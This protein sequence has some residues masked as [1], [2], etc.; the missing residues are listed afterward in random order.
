M[1]AS[2]TEVQQWG[3]GRRADMDELVG[4]ILFFLEGEGLHSVGCIEY[5]PGFDDSRCCPV[6]VARKA[7]WPDG[8]AHYGTLGAAHNKGG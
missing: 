6:H 5:P 4:A 1:K 2:A 8:W 3:V 7:L